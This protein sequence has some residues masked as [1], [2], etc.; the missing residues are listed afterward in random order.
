MWIS[1]H[2]ILWKGSLLENRRTGDLLVEQDTDSRVD[3]S[4]IEKFFMNPQTVTRNVMVC[5]GFVSLRPLYCQSSS[6]YSF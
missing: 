6:S 4:K 1:L 3:V 2:K 5:T